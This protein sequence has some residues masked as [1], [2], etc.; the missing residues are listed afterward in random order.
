MFLRVV[1]EERVIAFL[2]CHGGDHEGKPSGEWLLHARGVGAS[3]A[4]LDGMAGTFSCGS[5]FYFVMWFGFNVR[6]RGR[7][8]G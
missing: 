2:G 6:D 8:C 1:D 3:C 4:D 7:E 5:N